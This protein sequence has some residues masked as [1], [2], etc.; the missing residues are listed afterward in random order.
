MGGVSGNYFLTYGPSLSDGAGFTYAIVCSMTTR[1]GTLIG[2]DNYNNGH[3][4]LNMGTGDHT[5][6][7]TV[8]NTAGSPATAESGYNQFPLNTLSVLVGRITPAGVI[9]LFGDGVK[10]TTSATLGGAIKGIP[11]SDPL[12]IG[13]HAANTSVAF[14][15]AIAAFFR[16]NRALLDAEVASFSANPWQLFA[17]TS[18][19]VFFS[20]SQFARPIS[21][22]TPGAWV[23]V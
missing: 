1:G 17:P 23:G 3:R 10:A 4:N 14:P 11:A 20:S 6:T 5:V 21:D 9:D 13:T 15:G 12:Y 16:W 8:F 7:F 2:S 18:Y 19:P 22:I